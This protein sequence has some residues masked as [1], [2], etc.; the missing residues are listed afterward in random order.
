MDTSATN[1]TA[2]R[3]FVTARL[4]AIAASPNWIVPA[5]A[6]DI[7]VDN[8]AYQAVRRYTDTDAYHSAPAGPRDPGRRRLGLD[9][10]WL[11]RVTHSISLSAA[12]VA[13]LKNANPGQAAEAESPQ[14]R[15]ADLATRAR[16][17]QVLDLIAAIRNRNA[18]GTEPEP[19]HER[20]DHP[21]LLA[22]TA[23]NL[24][25]QIGAM[26]TLSRIV[27]VSIVA[28]GQ[29][30]TAVIDH[31]GELVDHCKLYESLG[32]RDPENQVVTAV[33]IGGS[34][35]LAMRYL[36]HDLEV[37]VRAQQGGS[38]VEIEERRGWWTPSHTK[39][40]RFK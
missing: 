27:L 15:V 13:T 22:L 7:N 12:D 17:T 21:E 16:L 3:A 32:L 20:D 25:R 26:G 40:V 36:A 18:D 35:P 19:G 8:D 38:I 24:E 14:G 11:Q 28:P 1:A 34:L 5:V 23:D 6:T 37:S 33:L 39:L 9:T 29:Q 10:V 31:H 4:A 30:V 2:L